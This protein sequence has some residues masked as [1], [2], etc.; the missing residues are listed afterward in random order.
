[1]HLLTPV[2]R[3]R[4]MAEL[5]TLEEALAALRDEAARALEDL[6]I[7]AENTGNDGL[8][9]GTNLVQKTDASHDL[10]P[11]AEKAGGW[12]GNAEDPRLE[13]KAA[14][15][16]EPTSLPLG[17]VLEACPDVVDYADGGHVGSWRAFI[18][19]AATIRPMIGIS[20]DAWRSARDTL[21]EDAAH[22]AV[23]A[24]LQR[25]IHSSE[26]LVVRSEE[27]RERV[28]VNGSPAIQSPGGYLRSL[29]EQANAGQVRGR[30]AADGADRPAAQGEAG[31]GLA[32]WIGRMSLGASNERGRYLSPP[33]RPS[34]HNSAAAG[35]RERPPRGRPSRPKRR[36]RPSS[37]APASCCARSP[38]ARRRRSALLVAT[39]GQK[40]ASH[41]WMN[42]ISEA[43]AMVGPESGM[44][45]DR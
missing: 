37:P 44:V 45:I 43:V 24:I 12:I 29:V 31:R 25:S 13:T 5:A 18:A 42:I 7:A 21:G 26:A 15:E 11:A 36:V 16:S 1:M 40:K 2:R 27:G 28:T 6:V 22:V 32:R 3:L 34:A 14:R 33:S 17:L 30:A 23:A 9:D 41:W 35:K 20:P 10:E 4:E 19:A 8:P 38:P 39:S